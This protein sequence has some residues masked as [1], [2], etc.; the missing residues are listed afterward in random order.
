MKSEDAL[1]KRDEM[2]ADYERVRITVDEH[3][4]AAEEG[5]S[6]LL[7]LQGGYRLLV[8]MFPDL[9]LEDKESDIKETP[10]EVV[11]G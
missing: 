8:E 5:R 6:E 1:K 4:R 11:N 9:A 7:K 10:A 3:E 2:V